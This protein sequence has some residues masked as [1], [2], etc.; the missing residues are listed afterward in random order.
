M[1]S[2][3]KSAT[4][5]LLLQVVLLALVLW[6]G[7]RQPN[8]FLHAANLK[9]ELLARATE[10]RLILVGGSNI[11][12]G[13]DSPTLKAHLPGWEPVSMSLTM[14]LGLPFV[15]DEVRYTIRQG[16]VVVI[17]P[18]YQLLLQ[19]RS[20]SLVNASFITE[21]LLGRPEAMDCVSPA[22]AMAMLDGGV[23]A[24]IGQTLRGFQLEHVQ[25]SL[26]P[27][28]VPPSLRFT[29]A[30]NET[31]DAVWHRNL[32]PVPFD[33]FRLK[34][35]NNDRLR[36]SVEMLNEFHDFCISRGAR[37]ILHYPPLPEPGESMKEMLRQIDK[38]LVAG[39]R[40][41]VLSPPESAFLP[42]DQFH[43]SYYHIGGGAIPAWTK[44]IADALR[45]NLDAQR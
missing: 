38:T 33:E 41:P 39:L 42:L 23:V 28:R 11:V 43:N 3:I 34:K 20:V 29:G 44:Q 10:P 40:F 19:G 32:P 12:Q 24:L 4:L 36:Q 17:I 30:F 18:E 25:K 37:C 35:V 8:G 9:H 2:F 45:P 26:P 27:K 6:F 5:F 1:K 13:V 15:L 14:S 7:C 16:D 31:G 22:A 21:M